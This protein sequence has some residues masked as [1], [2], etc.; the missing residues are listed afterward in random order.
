MALD[1]RKRQKK[2]AKQRAKRKAKASAQKG[3]QKSGSR[4]LSAFAGLEFELA[5]RAPVYKCYVA[6]DVFD[7]GIGHV[8]VSRLSGSQVAAG[9]YLVDAYCLGVKDAFAML[10]PRQ[11]FEDFIA[12]SPMR[13]REVEPAYAK[14]LVE[15]SIAYARD[16]GFEPHPDYKLPRKIL[17]G[18]DAS[19]CS[20]EFTFGKDGKPFFV[21]GPYD[22]EARSKR[23]V[24]TLHRRCGA[25]GYEYMVGI[26]PLGAFFED[27]DDWEDDDEEFED[28]DEDID[29]DEDEGDDLKRRI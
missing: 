22:S 27:D 15:A 18:I 6:D 1:Q 17:N 13:L 11:V 29:E 12:N 9:I 16:L 24:D 3:T 2:L 8:V 25:G 28:G 21:S 14:K 5:A 10:K 20:V 19:E 26:S 4:G 23:I 7:Q